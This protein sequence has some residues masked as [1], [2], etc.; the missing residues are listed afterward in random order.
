MA[1]PTRFPNGI[2][3]TRSIAA[4]GQFGQPDPMQ[5]HL[6][7]NDFDLFTSASWTNTTTGTGTAALTAGDG[8]WLALAT[9]ATSA[10]NVFLQKTT[11][12]FALN[13]GKQGW[14]KARFKVSA[15]TSQIVIG[16]QVTDTTPLDV[17]DGVYFLSAASTGVVTA[18]CRK[19]ATT[20]STSVTAG[21]LVADTF[22]EVA[23]Y[24][25]GKDSVE[26]FWNDVKVGTMTGIAANYLPDT[27]MTPS[28]GVQ[29]STATAK[30]MTI[31]YVMVATKR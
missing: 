8:G 13:P 3:T 21:T 4:L 11:E 2:G 12:G 17:T 20:G 31:D 10:D 28:F 24:W 5:Y 7:H 14:F 26:V 30:T 18:I 25:D 29:T 22:V 15:L 9:S 27:T 23:W 1:A 19:N 6:Y 16:L